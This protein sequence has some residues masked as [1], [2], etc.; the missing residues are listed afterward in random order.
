MSVNLSLRGKLLASFGAMVLLASALGFLGYRTAD[1]SSR[2]VEEL[3]LQRLPAVGAIKTI[4][5]A[6]GA[7]KEALMRMLNLDLAVEER[8]RATQIVADARARYGKAWEEFEALPHSTEEQAQW[9]ALGEIWVTWRAENSKFFELAKT[10]DDRSAAFN[11]TSS[12]ESLTYRQALTEMQLVTTELSLHA[13]SAVREWKNILLRGSDPEQM[14]QCLAALDA[15]FA[16]TDESLKALRTLAQDLS[17]FKA[18]VADV[19]QMVGSLRDGYRSSLK[20]HDPSDPAFAAAIDQEV[21]GVDRPMFAK[22][23]ALHAAVEK[24]MAAIDSLESRMNALA[25]G[26]CLKADI[27]ANVILDNLIAMNVSAATEAAHTATEDAR[28]AKVL[29][30]GALVG[31]AAVALTLALMIS[32]RL[33]KRLHELS[34]ALDEGAN[35]VAAAADQVAAS[36]SMLAEGSSEQAASLEET[37]ASLEEMSSMVRRNTE[38]AEDA[39]N[40]AREARTSA[41]GGASDM[42]AM[43]KAMNEIKASSDDIAKIIRTIDEIAFQTNILALN[44]A[45]EAARAGVAGAGFAVV[46]EE[47]RNLAQRTATSAKETA[48]KI[49]GAIHRAEQG[50]TI[51]SKV[52]QTFEAIIERVRNLDSL[53]AEVAAASKEQNQGISQVTIAVNEMDKVTQ[54]SAASAEESASAAQELSSQAGSLHDIVAELRAV[55]EGGKREDPAPHPSH[56]SDPDTR[57]LDFEPQ[58]TAPHTQKRREGALLELHR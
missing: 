36:G 32:N 2:T 5:E 39:S 11:A 7:V 47:V 15:Q 1:R 16:A 48:T 52:A 49:E 21:R 54:S 51:S 35:Q 27:A 41:D 22:L 58:H 43:I 12:A 20:K 17:L 46:A 24:E 31:S 33:S 18:E 26:P 4:K 38:I 56:P 30:V 19:E 53:V 10:Y 45:V 9:K 23:D 40:V 13:V 44:A 57:H 50:V 28:E 55:V 29:S 3:G 42:Q 6:S 37:S 14:K 25:L 34:T 8:Q